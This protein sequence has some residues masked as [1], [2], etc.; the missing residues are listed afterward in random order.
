MPESPSTAG[1]LAAVAAAAGGLTV[2]A[3]LERWLAH[4]RGRVRVVTYEGYET[5]LR[6][7]AL[8]R[9]GGLQLEELRPLE[10]QDLYAELLAG[11][12]ERPPLGAGT[13]LNLHLVL[14]QAFGQAVRWQLL[15]ANPVAGAQPPRPRRPARPLVDPPLL[16]TLLASVAGTWLEAPAAIAAAT[17]DAPRRNPRSPLGRPAE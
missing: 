7:H 3:Y 13:V 17:G 16:A 15:A 12:R 6:L 1:P 2:A 10:I 9:I 8:P 5:L 11:G 4:T 14:T